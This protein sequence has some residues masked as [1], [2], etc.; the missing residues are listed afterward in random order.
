MNELEKAIQDSCCFLTGKI[1]EQLRDDLLFYFHKS[2][3]ELAE[4][5]AEFVKQIQKTNRLKEEI[6][7]SEKSR[8]RLISHYKALVDHQV[9]GHDI[10]RISNN[11]FR[12]ALIKIEHGSSPECPDCGCDVD[13]PEWEIAHNA[14]MAEKNSLKKQKEFLC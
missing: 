10:M 9:K 3:T 7:L 5:K 12:E 14:L 1:H 4:Y 8:N 6:E 13:W 11:I 2:T